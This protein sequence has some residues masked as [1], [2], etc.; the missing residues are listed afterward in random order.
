MAYKGIIMLSVRLVS[1]CFDVGSDVV[2]GIRF[3]QAHT[4]TIPEDPL[5]QNET[6]FYN[7]CYQFDGDGAHQPETVWGA[8]TLTFVFLPGM[9]IGVVYGMRVI[10][11]N[12]KDCNNWM[13]ALFWWFCIAIFPICFPLYI[14]YNIGRLILKKEVAKKASWKIPAILGMEASLEAFPNLVLQLHTI[15]RGHDITGIQ[16][17]AIGS[18]LTSIVIASIV[19]DIENGKIGK[20]GNNTTKKRTLFCERL[21]CY[22]TTIIFRGLALSLCTSYLGRWS[23]FPV[24]ILLVE[25]VIVATIR[26]K[27]M[28]LGLRRKI[29]GIVYLTLSNAGTMNAFSMVHLKCQEEKGTEEDDKEVAKFV[30]MSAIVTTIHHFV[31]LIA[32]LV[33]SSIDPTLFSRCQPP[34]FLLPPSSNDFYWTFAVTMIFGIYSIV[35]LMYRAKYIVREKNTGASKKEE[36]SA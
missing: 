19:S 22:L 24:F 18:S 36:L 14:T 5:L 10:A 31:V 28:K 2:N 9:V 15:L 16:K 12:W 21:P 7:T 34:D 30:K 33:V 23:F 26:M 6:K 1:Y 25:L 29:N 17:F 8:L 20:V 4:H 32:L 11:K 13:F 3:L 35:L 27:K